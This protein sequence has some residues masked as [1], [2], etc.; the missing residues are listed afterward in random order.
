MN[1]NNIK[2]SEGQKLS[3]VLKEIP[4]N[5]ILCKTVP[6]NGATYCEIKAKRNS[7]IIEPNKPVIVGKTVAPKHKEDNLLGVYEGVTVDD[8]IEYIIRT[9]KYKK[10]IKIMTTPES[11]NKI[12]SAAQVAGQDIANTCFVLFDECHKTVE[13]IDYREN[14]TL[15][16]DFFFN[17]KMKAIV[18]AT[19]PRYNYTDQRLK[20]FTILKITPDYDYRH[21]IDLIITNNVL[22]EVYKQIEGNDTDT[23]VFFFVNSTDTIYALMKQTGTLDNSYVF[24]SQKSVLKL[25]TYGFDNASEDWLVSNKKYNWLTSRFYSAVDL[26]MDYKP[27]VVMITECNVA[28][29]TMFNPFTDS[30]QIVGRFRNGVSKVIH[31]TNIKQ[32]FPKRS[33]EDIL[34]KYECYKDTYQA[35]MDIRNTSSC[36]IMIEA[37]DEAITL[38][39]YTR[40]LNKKTRKEDCFLIDNYIDTEIVKGYYHSSDDIVDAYN[41]SNYFKS[42]RKDI[43]YPWGESEKLQIEN[44]RNEVKKKRQMVIMMLEKI[45]DLDCQTRLRLK[46][47]LQAID[48]ELVEAYEIIGKERIEQLDYS[49][50]KIKKEI[51][52][53]QHKEQTTSSDVIKTIALTFREGCTYYNSEIVE[54]ITKIYE[55]FNVLHKQKIQPKEITRFF[56]TD[57]FRNHKGRG[58]KLI[59]SRYR[60]P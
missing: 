27:I 52:L 35:I 56:E 13:D 3:S 12:V 23:S 40:F 53:K 29:F 31:I 20:D 21:D 47:Q 11:F 5:T 17:C 6:G 10:F 38:L 44:H 41:Q 30:P 14:I 60:C 22:Q 32:D 1:K 16:L 36:D 2:I 26:E 9:R 57:V 34:L 18:S 37:L 28:E 8:I 33:M 46:L 48:K 43:T 24:C 42:Y 50:S 7:I 4:S 49:I 51:I 54:G 25:H 58:Y 55:T 45:K 39:P 19:L 59:K 15:P